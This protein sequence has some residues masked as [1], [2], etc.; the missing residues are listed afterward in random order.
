MMKA[1][2]YQSEARAAAGPSGLLSPVLLGLRASDVTPPLMETDEHE[3][4]AVPPLKGNH[5][6][7][8]A[9]IEQGEESF[10]HVRRHCGAQQL[11]PFLVRS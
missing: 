11:H 4:I 10:V 1:M 8:V 2:R 6:G 7:L 3:V 9:N 5:T